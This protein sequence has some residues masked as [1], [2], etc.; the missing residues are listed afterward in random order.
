M[1]RHIGKLQIGRVKTACLEGDRGHV[2]VGLEFVFI[3]RYHCF[4]A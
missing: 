4:L 3:S 2:G 1:G